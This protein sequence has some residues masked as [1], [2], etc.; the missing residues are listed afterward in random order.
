MVKGLVGEQVIEEGVSEWWTGRWGEG[1]TD[2]W[3][4]K[5]DKQNLII[6]VS[7]MFFW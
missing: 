2:K 6:V 4:E 7:V 3:T 1:W 5:R